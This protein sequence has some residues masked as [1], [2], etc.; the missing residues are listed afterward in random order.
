MRLYHGSKTY[1]ESFD[2]A[3][4]GTGEGAAAYGHGVYLAE[5]RD[6]GDTYRISLAYDPDKMRVSGVQINE[7]YSRIERQ[8]CK[9]HPTDAQFEHQ[10]LEILE[11]L[12]MHEP[13]ESLLESVSEM[14][15][16]TWRWFNERVL[17]SFESFGFLYEVN[18]KLEHEDMLLDWDA[19]LNAQDE[20]L[21]EAFEGLLPEAIEAGELT[22]DS[23]GEQAYR[24]LASALGSQV[25]ASEAL[26][27]VGIKGLW[28]LDNLSR[29]K[30]SPVAPET[31]NVVVFDPS[32]IQI[33]AINGKDMEAASR[34]YSKGKSLSF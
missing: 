3:A 21:W 1:F 10:Q 15:P 24:L 13:P 5:H 26:N 19:T 12:M 34:K 9:K 4:A 6:V 28:Y 23:T 22:V 20:R 18:L 30:G 29:E 16:Q 33:A 14:L 2:L 27:G 8:A 17:P 7:I 11:N 31:R 32:A 25:K